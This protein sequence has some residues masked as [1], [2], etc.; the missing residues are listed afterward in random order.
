[1]RARLATEDWSAMTARANASPRNVNS[2]ERWRQ[3]ARE[4]N[5]ALNDA[6]V[7]RLAEMLRSDYYAD[8]ARR[9]AASRRAAAA[10]RAEATA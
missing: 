2:L 7:D 6:Q 9:S 5:P 3:A 10:R 1:V 8:L 4:K